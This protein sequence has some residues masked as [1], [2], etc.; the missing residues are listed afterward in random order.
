MTCT[1]H[2]HTQI[3]EADPGFPRGED[4]NSPGGAP[5]YNF[6]KISQKLHEIERIWTPGGGGA[7]KILLCRFA[8]EQVFYLCTPLMCI[9]K[10]GCI[11]YNT[12]VELCQ[13]LESL[14]HTNTRI[15]GF[16]SLKRKIM[17]AENYSDKMQCSIDCFFLIS[18][19]Y[20]RTTA[21][22]AQLHKNS[23][24]R[25]VIRTVLT[26]DEKCYHLKR[27]TH[28]LISYGLYQTFN[29]F[30]DKVTYLV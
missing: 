22:R 24:N 27:N 28:V 9:G 30:K 23:G 5:T 21:Q 16:E 11:I 18:S 29:L 3:A 25:S 4:A 8:T 2:F 26:S 12:G 17:F 14:P 10:L 6:V 7:T 19:F 15:K 13:V 20:L 1:T